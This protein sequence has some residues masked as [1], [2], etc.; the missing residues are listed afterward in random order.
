MTAVGYIRVSSAGDSDDR[1]LADIE[2]DREFRDKAGSMDA[3]RPGLR[4]CLDW[5]REGDT[6]HVQSID[7]LALNIQDL[8]RIIEV[9]S[10]KGVDVKFHKEK[11]EFSG[12]PTPTRKMQLRM[13]DAFAEFELY[14]IRERRNEGREAAKRAGKQVGA[15]PKLT[16]KQV[17]ELRQRVASGESKKYLAQEFGISRQT[18]YNLV[19]RFEAVHLVERK[20]LIEPVDKEANIYESGCWAIGAQRADRLVGADI[21]FHRKQSEPSF[22]G[23]R[24][25][26]WREQKIGKYKGRVIFAF[27]Q[28]EDHIGVEA[29]RDGWR[30]G[31]KFVLA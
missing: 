10:G 7:R 18:L 23:G 29:G 14:L 21:Y 20:K 16:D 24:I 8:Q 5:C 9:L 22:D 15:K 11:L 28:T 2:L 12:R 19:D 4:D 1:Q 6:L 27:E 17:A 30:M 13:V 26:A 25:T 3:D 31:Y